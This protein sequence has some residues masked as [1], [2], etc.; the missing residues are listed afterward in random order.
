MRHPFTAVGAELRLDYEVVNQ[1]VA[2]SKN[3]LSQVHTVPDPYYVSSAFQTTSQAKMIQFVHLPA[4]YIIRIYSTN[5][6]LVA[7]LEHHSATFGRAE[8]W[9]VLNR[10]N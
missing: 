4:D 1:V 3:D 8:T 5:G 2:A 6:A 10:N 9:N 7:L